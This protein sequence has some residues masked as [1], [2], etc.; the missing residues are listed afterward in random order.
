MVHHLSSAFKGSV[1]AVTKVIEFTDHRVT[2]SWC[3]KNN[4]KI[5]KLWVFDGKDTSAL[6]RIF[7]L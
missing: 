6:F 4:K 3:Y 7:F 2:P 5:K 1:H